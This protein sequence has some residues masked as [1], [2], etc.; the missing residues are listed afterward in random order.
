MGASNPKAAPSLSEREEI[1][2]LKATRSAF[3]ARM[4]GGNWSISETESGTR[5]VDRLDRQIARRESKLQKESPIP[6]AP[7]S[8]RELAALQQLSLAASYL[9]WPALEGAL[10]RAAENADRIT[11]HK[12]TSERWMMHLQAAIT[13]KA[14]ALSN[15][16]IRASTG[17]HRSLVSI[18]AWLH[19][20]EVC[21]G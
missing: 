10:T 19:A 15:P 11:R 1:A 14:G 6:A 21:N 13:I 9:A 3:I 7:M 17:S 12:G 16:A 8:R 2:K 5:T 20:A 4:D 18:K